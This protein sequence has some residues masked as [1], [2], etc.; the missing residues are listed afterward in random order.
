MNP[1]TARY[2]PPLVQ[3][4]VTV[5]LCAVP[6]AAQLEIPQ[7]V[8]ASG[9]TEMGSTSYSVRG[10][11]GQPA[12]GVLKGDNTSALTGYWLLSSPL[13]TGIGDTP[14]LPRVYAMQQNYPNPF[15]PTTTI[16]FALPQ[17]SFVQL[18][19]YN[20]S[21]QRVAELVSERRPAGVYKEPFDASSLASGIYFYRMQAEGF[22]QTRKLVLLK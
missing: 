17:E 21:G 5:L 18:N 14:N 3:L 22:V 10:T 15:N 9:G 6:A 4:V 20:V 19:V 12:A 2:I 13:P 7:R 16:E 11:V 1:T 8:I